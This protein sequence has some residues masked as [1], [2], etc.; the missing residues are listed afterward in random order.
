MDKSDR[1]NKLNFIS[2]THTRDFHFILRFKEQLPFCIHQYPSV[3]SFFLPA[4]TIT[5]LF[6]NAHLCWR[7]QKSGTQNFWRIRCPTLPIIHQLQVQASTL[8]RASSASWLVQISWK[9]LSLI[10]ANGKSITLHGL[11]LP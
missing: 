11:T 5:V 2:R 10:F 4:H 8:L 3:Y 7:I 6:R 9:V 1:L